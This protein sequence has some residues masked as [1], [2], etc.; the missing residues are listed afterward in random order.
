MPP[1][2]PR[3]RRDLLLLRHGETEWNVAGR[4]QG[5]LDVAL[6]AEGELQARR[7]G[8][9]LRLDA[10]RFVAVASSDLTRARRTAELITAAI[11]G[12]EVV[13]DAGFRERCGGRFE[14]LDAAAID[15]GWPGFRDRWRAGLEDAPPEGESDATVW[16]R[17]AEALDRL[18]RLVPAGPMLVVTHGGVLRVAAE[19]S[20]IPTRS[21]TP[22]VGGRWYGWDGERLHAGDE[23]RPLPDTDHTK[24]AIE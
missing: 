7:R 8:E 20:G 1:N 2:T 21:V 3:P 23:I 24:P 15:A 4:W 13:T 10:A 6:A 5:W 16:S 11:G 19:R 18:D 17:F 9:A 14:G 12:P 22:T